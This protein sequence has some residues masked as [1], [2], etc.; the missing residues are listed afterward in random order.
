MSL[1]MSM[2]SSIDGRAS[3]GWYKFYL[4]TVAGREEKILYTGHILETS[5]SHGITVPHSY[6]YQQMLGAFMELV[7]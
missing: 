1:L 7:M 4:K 2:T 3:M 5:K 6:L